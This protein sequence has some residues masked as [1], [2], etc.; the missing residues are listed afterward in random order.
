MWYN[1]LKLN[2]Y[3]IPGCIYDMDCNTEKLLKTNFL[4]IILRH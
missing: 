2:I 4:S 1:E 3:Y